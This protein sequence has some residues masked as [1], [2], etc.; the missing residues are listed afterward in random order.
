MEHDKPS[1]DQVRAIVG[2]HV[3]EQYAREPSVVDT[4][5]GLD[6]LHSQLVDAA[7][8][9]EAGPQFQRQAICDAIVATSEF[10]RG[11]GFGNA[12]TVPL[13]RV[14]WAIV[15]LCKQNHPDPLFCKKPRRSKSKRNMEDAVRQGQLAAFADAWLDSST[16]DEGNEAAKLE[17]AARLMSGKHFGA[18]DGRKL[19]SAR[20]YQRQ[21][22]Q[23]EL[24]YQ[25][26]KQMI[27]A[28]TTEANA[29]GGD[30]A[31]LRTAI[32]VQIDALNAEAELLKS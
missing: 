15:D 7:Q 29:A 21:M 6:R 11:Q 1:K 2:E 32:Q 22:G 19:A 31:G 4:S 20:S 30:S 18:L 10:L 5:A 9:Y 27:D 16:S 13:S 24:V 26:H 17:R 8:A 14:L 23:H 28:L 3:A 25:S 12:A